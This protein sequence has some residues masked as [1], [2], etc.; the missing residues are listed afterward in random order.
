MAREELE[1]RVRFWNDLD[2]VV[3][4]VSNKYRLCGFGDLNRWV[5]AI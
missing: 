1:E 2:R 3:D 4:R 5:G